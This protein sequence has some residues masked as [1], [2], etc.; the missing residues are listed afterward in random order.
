MTSSYSTEQHH[1]TQKKWKWQVQTRWLEGDLLSVPVAD[2]SSF[3]PYATP[4]SAVLG[5]GSSKM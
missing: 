3:T 5:L 1:N 4:C 2:R